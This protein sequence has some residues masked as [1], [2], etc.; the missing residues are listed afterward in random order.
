[1]VLDV[2]DVQFIL[3][4]ILNIR[5]DGHV[6]GAF[7]LAYGIGS[8]GALL[9]DYKQDITQLTAIQVGPVV[10]G[11]VSHLNFTNFLCTSTNFSH[12]DLR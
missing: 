6:Y 3:P 11:Q 5:T 2:S 10:A 1:M 9:Y 8:A 12:A 7:N 4:S